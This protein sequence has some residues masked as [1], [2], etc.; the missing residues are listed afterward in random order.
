M[1]H[2][3]PIDIHDHAYGFRRSAHIDGCAECRRAVETVS[4]ERGRMKQVLVLQPIRLDSKLLR[5][6]Q[7][8]ESPRTETRSSLALAAAGL[9]LAGILW[10]ILHESPQKT[11]RP[12][13]ADSGGQ[14]RPPDPQEPVDFLIAQ[15]KSPSN[16]RRE[17]AKYALRAYGRTVYERLFAA[18]ADP[19]FLAEFGYV[20]DEDRR[21]EAKLKSTKV[22][23][24][25]KG[26]LADI[27][28]TLQGK[29]GVRIS[30]EGIDTRE[31]M[32]LQ[33]SDVP[34]NSALRILLESEGRI[35]SIKNGGIL[36]QKREHFR[37]ELPG[38][39]P[40]RL[41]EAGA[42]ARRYIKALSDGSL[43][44][45]T[46]A[47]ERLQNLNFAAEPALWEGLDS[48]D[49]KVRTRAG[50]LL[51]RLY[52]PETEPALPETWKK[53]MESRPNFDFDN[54]IMAALIEW[55]SREP[56]CPF[57]FDVADLE[58]DDSL[59][60]RLRVSSL[61]WVALD[62]VIVSALKVAR[63]W[64]PR[65]EPIWTTPEKAANVERLIRD[66]TSGDRSQQD[67]AADGL[68]ALG[69]AALDPL[70]QASLILDGEEAVRCRAVCLRIIHAL[71]L[72]VVNEP[73]GA[74]LQ[75]LSEGQK[76]VLGKK[77]TLV[78]NGST[79]E[80]FLNRQGV[81]HLLKAEP[82]RRLNFYLQDVS[83]ASFLKCLLRP[84]RLDFYMDGETIVIDTTANVRA[85]V[86][87]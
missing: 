7:V 13:P 29:S 68:I 17:M 43:D 65:D 14:P 20:T 48:A 31:L 76:S 15:L 83:L 85:A 77:L 86:E 11:V 44:E 67:A 57:V 3:N 46:R 12:Q 84:C 30:V 52:T 62:D 59:Q 23:L 49:P 5:T 75:K 42:A 70:R 45:R 69:A 79:L 40:I 39:M 78:E 37:R 32:H 51:R 28:Q 60:L 41:G 36:I 47:L 33:V 8:G 82:A 66:L 64:R 18:K 53:L 71:G 2:A 10:M 87:K 26:T 22:E 50:D 58:A 74:D 72:W 63:W 4:A 35:H 1:N 61:E 27:L 80:E 55:M 34:I 38:R 9:F 54:T 25:M 24:D 81:K 73:A 21:I 16:E 19:E 56:K 6:L